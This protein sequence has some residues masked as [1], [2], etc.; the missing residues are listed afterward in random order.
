M[1]LGLYP[2][3]LETD[4]HL[5]L[6][7]GIQEDY[8]DGLYITRGFDRNIMV[9]TVQAFETIYD[10]ITSLNLADPVARLLLR[11]ILGAAHRTEIESD[12]RLSIPESLREFANLERAVTIVGQGDFIE[13]WSPDAWNRQEEQLLNVEADHFSTLNITI[14]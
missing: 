13:L 9:L 2:S 1:L 6:P 11:M 8:K 5:V 7:D 12:G 10:R 4:N 14:Q 3:I